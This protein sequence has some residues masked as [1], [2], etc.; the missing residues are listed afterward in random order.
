MLI[1]FDFRVIFA[2]ILQVIDTLFIYINTLIIIYFYNTV[3]KK[4]K[5]KTII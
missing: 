4:I 5:T 1:L 2:P 3:M